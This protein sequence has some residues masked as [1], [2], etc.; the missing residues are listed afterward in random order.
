MS[1][2]GEIMPGGEPQPSALG[3]GNAFGRAAERAIAPQTYFDEDQHFAVTGNEI[4][5]SAAA[6]IVALNDRQPA[7]RK[8]AC[9]ERFGRGAAV[10]CVGS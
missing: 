8:I 10:H 4:D 3:S 9:R 7:R 2:P 5:F 1:E 6:A